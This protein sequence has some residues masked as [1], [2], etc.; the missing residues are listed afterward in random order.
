[1]EIVS[2]SEAL[3]ASLI[4]QPFAQGILDLFVKSS[5]IIGL[6][7]AIAR[8]FRTVL[9]N[10][11]SHLLW[12]N[13]LFCIAVLPFAGSAISTFTAGLV[14][15]GAITI[16]M[17]QPG[18]AE[19]ADTSMVT[20]NLVFSAV[21]LVVAL[22]FLVRLLLSAIGLRR[23]SKSAT[24]VSSGKTADQM[25][26]TAEKLDLKR[27]VLLK[28]SDRVNSP[29]SFGL[30]RP[31]V[32]LPSAAK[33]WS[34]S[35][36]EDVLLHELSHIKRLDWPTMLFCHLLS[37]LFWI[38]PLVW[39]AKQ[40][41]NEAAEK[42]C[43]S[44]ILTHGKDGPSYAEDLLQFAKMN[45]GKQV[46]VLAQLMFDESGLSVRIR[47]I[48][49]G[50]LSGK[51]NKA[52]MTT[53]LGYAVVAVVL[54]SNINVFGAS[55]D[56]QDQEYLPI[57]AIAPLYPTRAAEEGIE[58]WILLSF[59]VT[60]DGSVDA[61]SMQVM[62][63]EPADIF[64]RSALRAAEKFLFQPRIIDGNAVEVPGV[65]Y[66]FRYVLEDGGNLD[67]LTRQPPPSR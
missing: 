34:K 45:R 19:S 18:I 63:A 22:G 46:P 66:L 25:V 36:M 53:M 26:I 35:T 21:Y 56:K 4:G 38:N 15:Q 57:T 42:A 54:F 32:L 29:M 13:C 49:D 3:S 17:V 7:F 8:L 47:N 62:D 2:L 12:L 51:I 20:A 44:A 55:D 27:N 67:D 52:F 31:V 30:L 24:V 65:Q 33:S 10:N 37:S 50:N 14:G 41:V 6:T 60:E 48:L 61:S 9:S 59:T 39:F 40:R 5:I 11:S 23:I 1:M 16:I 28:F 43:D 64:D 58:G